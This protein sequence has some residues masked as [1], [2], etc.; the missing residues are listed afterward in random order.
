M[1]KIIELDKDLI[2][3]IAAGEVVERPASVIKELVENAID[4]EAKNIII[5]VKEGG[6]SFIRVADDGSGMSK[7]DAKLAIKKH[8]TSK[9]KS[10][11]DLFRISTLGFRGEAL[12][13]IASVSRM[14]IATK[15]I[16]D[17][18]GIKLT[19]ENSEIIKEEEV[20][21]P[22]GTSIT[23]EDIFYNTPARKNHLK[24]IDVE[25]AHI[26]EIVQKYALAYPEVGFRLA[27]NG[28]DVLLAPPTEDPLGNIVNIF[29]LDFAKQL[30][31]VKVNFEFGSA[32]GFVGKPSLNRGDKSLIITFINN[33]YIRNKE[34]ADSVFE[35]YHSLLNTQRFPVAILKFRI[36]F[37]KIDVN[38]HPTKIDV[39][40][41]RID[42]ICEEL[43]VAIKNVL[44]E[45]DLVP[46]IDFGQISQT[47]ISGDLPSTNLYDILSKRSSLIEQLQEYKNRPTDKNQSVQTVMNDKSGQG[48]EKLPQDEI[49]KLN[50]EI[51]IDENLREQYGLK[52]RTQL[53]NAGAGIS[54]ITPAFNI[55]G[56]IHKTFIV[57]ET[58]TG[59]RMVDLHAAH[60]RVNYELLMNRF[61]NH[62]IKSQEL[63]EPLQIQ[64]TLDEAAIIRANMKTFEELGI[65]LEEFGETNF[66]IRT[67]PSV[68]G[69]QFDKE[70][71]FDMIKDAKNEKFDSIQALA[72]HWIHTMACRASAKAGDNLEQLEMSYLVSELLKCRQPHTCPHGRPTMIDFSV[73]DFEKFFNRIRGYENKG[74]RF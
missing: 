33:R 64:V 4:A 7:E 8:T 37:D 39:R 48:F 14:E 65:T 31:K 60:E 54:N 40:I 50:A 21:T 36:P 67:L 1:G 63:I 42:H 24:G 34:L 73:R 45:N 20:G 49:D 38:V 29:G 59:M 74:C 26:S 69:R 25:F 62:K 10:N 52:S 12:A 6:K 72:E 44:E 11:Q 2:N 68:L 47:K 61:R 70:V 3:K 9:I 19:I 43:M 23:V 22:I 18:E 5:E 15:T 46:K 16:Y 57:I 71:I 28:R 27:H 53:S 56:K 35:A 55:L 17:L 41:D 30:L 66:L 51:L 13:S 32:E 58:S